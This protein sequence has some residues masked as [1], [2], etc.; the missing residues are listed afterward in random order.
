MIEVHQ[1]TVEKRD[2]RKGKVLVE[3]PMF[4]VIRKRSSILI[5]G[6]FFPVNVVEEGVDL[7]LRQ[8]SQSEWN[9]DYRCIQ[10]ENA[11]TEVASGKSPD[12]CVDEDGE[13]SE[14]CDSVSL[15]ERNEDLNW[16][17]VPET[18]LN[19]VLDDVHEETQ[20]DKLIN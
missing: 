5:Q 13:T 7:L 4:E 2:C 9:L 8:F 11:R 15:E 17:Y 19:E 16:D 1:E 18:S 6:E 12:E 3:T 20:K 10:S 14:W